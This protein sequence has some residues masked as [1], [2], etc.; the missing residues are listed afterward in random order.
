MK[1]DIS[2]SPEIEEPFVVIH[3]KEMNSEIA[4]LAKDISEYTSGGKIIGNA[5][6]RMIVLEADTISV[7]RV[8]DEKVYVVSEG[9]TYR[10][11]KR[12]YELLEVLGKDFMQVSKSASINLKYLKSVEPYFNGVMVLHLKDGEKEYISRKYVPALK[13]YLGI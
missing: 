9:T 7:I 8:E 2:I 6:D 1:V 12:M 5:E 10:V 11:G 3:T 13:K 4:E